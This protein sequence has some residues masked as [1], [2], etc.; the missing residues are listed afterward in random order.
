MVKPVVQDEVGPIIRINPYELHI[1]DPEFYDEL[2]VGP[3]KGKT[4]KW[5][6]SVDF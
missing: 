3:T 2:Y 1:N 6:Y 4:D 5:W